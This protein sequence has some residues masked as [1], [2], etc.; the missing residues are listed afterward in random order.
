M[1]PLAF[2]PTPPVRPASA[3]PALFLDRDGVLN[4]NRADYVRT[5]EQVVMLPGVEGA[6]RAL[7]ATPYAVVV[8][9]NQSAVGRGLMTAATLAEINRGIVTWI[10]QAGGRVDAVYACPHTPDAGCRCRKPRP[11]MLTQAAAD[12]NLDLSRSWLVGDAVSDLEAAAAAGC[13]PLLVLTGRG[14]RQQAHLHSHPLAATPV[15][16]NLAAAAQWVLGRAE[17]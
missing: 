12:L 8:V 4:E 16:P 17:A 9:T 1:Q 15:L 6:L 7:A 5:P 3:R 10:E 2:F 13:H 14:A 11:G